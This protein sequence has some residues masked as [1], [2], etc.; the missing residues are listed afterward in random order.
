MELEEVADGGEAVDAG[1]SPGVDGGAEVGEGEPA[2]DGA[3][4][5]A[6]EEGAFAD[7]DV[8]LLPGTVEAL[9]DAEGHVGSLKV[10]P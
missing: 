2:P 8:V 5:D 7:G 9:P 6:D 10:T 4:G 3:L 1:A